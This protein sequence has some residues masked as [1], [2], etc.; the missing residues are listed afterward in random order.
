VKLFLACVAA[1][2]LVGCADEPTSTSGDTE[3]NVS[4]TKTPQEP[5]TRERDTRD[6]IIAGIPAGPV[7]EFS[8]RIGE[9]SENVR[10][11]LGDEGV[12]QD[13]EAIA[14]HNSDGRVDDT[15]LWQLDGTYVCGIKQTATRVLENDC[16]FVRTK[17]ASF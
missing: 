14:I 8:A 1:L 2:S 15:T 4:G 12:C 7:V 11:D 10:F 6:A 5:L 16:S 9:W 3:I 13:C 17:P